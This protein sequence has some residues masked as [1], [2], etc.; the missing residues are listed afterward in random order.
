MN[1]KFARREARLRTP[2]LVTLLLSLGACNTSDLLNETPGNNGTE[3]SVPE[4]PDAPSF[5]TA[6]AGGIPMGTFALPTSWF[7]SPYN[8]ALRNIWPGEL[9]H[10]LAAIKARGGKVVL[11]FAGNERYYKDGS[12]HF[13]LTKWKARIDRFRNVNFSSYLRDGTIIAHYL[14]DEPTDPHNWGGRPVTPSTLE[15]MAR[16]SK[17]RWPS[18]ATVVR[19]EPG[20]IKWSNKYRY[21]DAAWAQYLYRKGNPSDYI[22]RVVSDAQRMGL[23]LVV[24]LN[25]TK[26]S[27]TKGRMS[28]S[29]VRTAGGALLGSSYPCAFISWTYDANHLSSSSMKDAM[30]YLRSRAQSRATRNCHS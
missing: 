23:A 7:G 28:A 1:F 12:G 5:A 15:E 22:R 21:L 3:V 13:S 29:Q 8:G 11:M 30:R 25:I 14:I 19:A 24:G 16:Y 6:F 26:G 18:M 20:L 10:E 4:T 27:P 2:L 9:L 17:S